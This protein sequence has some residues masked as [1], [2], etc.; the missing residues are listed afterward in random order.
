M[1]TRS[2]PSYQLVIRQQPVAARA[3]GFGERDRRVI[4]PPPILQMI[5]EDPYASKDEI[6]NKLRDPYNVVHCSLYHA[7][8][9]E[10]DSLMPETGER[11]QQRR[12]M[13]QLVSSPF[14]GLDENGKEGSFFCFPDLSCRTSGKYRLEFKLVII[15]QESPRSRHPCPS[16]VISQVFQVFAAKDF[17]GMQESTPLTKKLKQQGC[18]ISVKKGNAK[19]DAKGGDDGPI[20]H[21]AEYDDDDDDDDEDEDD[22]EEEEPADD[23]EEDNEA[24]PVKSKAK[25]RVAK[26]RMKR[27]RK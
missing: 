13:G 11:R 20:H 17:P 18:Q 4:D 15:D 2:E 5:L 25:S 23:D 16:V 26:G 12:L 24:P 9:E 22:E 14:Y 3:C 27:Q 19:K 1:V 8:R 6:R 10:S 21:R 7:D